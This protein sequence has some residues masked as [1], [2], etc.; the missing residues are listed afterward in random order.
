MTL[1]K[2]GLEKPLILGHVH[3]KRKIGIPNEY[4][5]SFTGL[6]T[7]KIKTGFD[8]R[9]KHLPIAPQLLIT[10]AMFS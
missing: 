10:R 5:T 2:I 4:N 6:R 7:I 8:I 9:N 1:Q 3:L